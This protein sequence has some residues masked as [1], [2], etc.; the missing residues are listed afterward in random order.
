[1]KFRDMCPKRRSDVVEKSNYRDYRDS[2]RADFNNRCGY[3]NDLDNPRKEYF[4]IDHLVP[5]KIMVKKKKT[6][7]QNLV[8]ACHSCNNAKR[9]K[10]PSG[11]ENIPVVGNKGWVDPCSEKYAKQF[12]RD[13]NGNIIPLTPI[14]EWMYDNL[15][16]YK[17][18]HSILWNLEQI[19]LIKDKLSDKI[20]ENKDNTPFLLQV[21]SLCLKYEDLFEKFFKS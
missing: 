1:M 20:P 9:K 12:S 18:Q 8:Y 11:D 6:D 3:C 5:Q 7:Y 21:I 16:L 2:L 14:G 19:K 4:E 10:W 13:D 17:P 15:K